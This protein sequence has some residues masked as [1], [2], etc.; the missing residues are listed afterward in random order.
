MDNFAERFDTILKD[1]CI[2]QAQVYRKM[3]MPQ[4]TFLYK[5]KHGLRSWNVVEFLDMVAILS[6]SK[7]EFDFLTNRVA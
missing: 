5:K 1:K 2:D 6:L 7:E 3:G 4:S